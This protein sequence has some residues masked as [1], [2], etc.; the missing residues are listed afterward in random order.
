MA[1][2]TKNSRKTTPA[3]NTP[4]RSGLPNSTVQ[5]GNLGG[6]TAEALRYTAP[7]PVTADLTSQ[8]TAETGAGIDEIS[9]RAYY[10]S[11][12]RR[13]EGTPGDDVSDWLQAENELLGSTRLQ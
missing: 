8:Q 6:G 13:N 4:N 11:E 7:D 12:R 1:T 3:G 2:S 5:R 10:L 9:L